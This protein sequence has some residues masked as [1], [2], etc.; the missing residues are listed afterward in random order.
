[1]TYAPYWGGGRVGSSNAY[2]GVVKGSLREILILTWAIS[3]LRMVFSAEPGCDIVMMDNSKGKRKANGRSVEGLCGFK[4][5][6]QL[7]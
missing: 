5:Q 2:D 3:I 7:Q 4:L 1:M 6:L